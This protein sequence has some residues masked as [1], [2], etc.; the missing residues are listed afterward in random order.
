MRTFSL[1]ALTI[2]AAMTAAAQDA[3][4]Q[5]AKTQE[6]KA[7]DAKPGELKDPVEILKKA[8]AATLAV[9]SVRYKARFSG[10]G[11]AESRVPRIEGVAVLAGDKG[12]NPTRFMFEAE[13]RPPGS[14]DALKVKAGG[15]GSDF[16]VIN[17][18][19]KKVHT[20]IDPDVL[21]RATVLLRFFT[22][23][24]FT[25]PKPFSDEIN[26]EKQEL[27]GKT[28]IG[29]EECYEVHVTY[30][31]MAQEAV[32]YFSTRDF[33][34]RRVDRISSSGQGGDRFE[35]RLELTELAVDPSFVKDP[36]KLDMPEGYEKT[37][38]PMD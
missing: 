25:H 23:R 6:T 31:G 9:K 20:D 4:P 28:K 30:Q 21:G 26:G 19:E 2:A 35:S 34:P 17:E 10:T 3:K 33:L 32:W 12:D 8:D 5:D 7:Q 15:D 11:A 18:K 14:D 27:R 1:V 37:D 36:F 29:G 38:E 22:M 13:I 24:E 16:W